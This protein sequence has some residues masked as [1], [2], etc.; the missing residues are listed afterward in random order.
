[1]KNVRWQIQSRDLG[2]IGDFP[3]LEYGGGGVGGGGGGG[4]GWGVKL[5][6][7]N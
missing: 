3:N 6:G 5:L 7:V 2:H 4:C 1:M